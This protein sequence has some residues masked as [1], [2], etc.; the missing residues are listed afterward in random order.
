MNCLG[1]QSRRGRLQ[2]NIELGKAERA[3]SGIY[4]VKKFGTDRLAFKSAQ[5]TLPHQGDWVRMLT[6]HRLVLI[7][8]GVDA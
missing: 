7:G 6:R 5:C 2:L 8:L 3:F 4:V 1:H